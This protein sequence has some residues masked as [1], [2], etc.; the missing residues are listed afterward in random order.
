MIAISKPFMVRWAGNFT[1]IGTPTWPQH[2]STL[3]R[4]ELLLFR[5]RN[6]K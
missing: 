6:S 3:S 4:P 1:K 2:P 5:I